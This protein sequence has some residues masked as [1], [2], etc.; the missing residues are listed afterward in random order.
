MGRGEGVVINLDIVNLA[1]VIGRRYFTD[2]D[3][4]GGDGGGGDNGNMA[5]GGVGNGGGNTTVDINGF[6]AKAGDG[7]GTGRNGNIIR[8]R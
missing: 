8:G 2:I 7:D 1:G 6:G 5:P 3:C 4:I